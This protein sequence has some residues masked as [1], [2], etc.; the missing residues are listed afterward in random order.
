MDW[1]MVEK[2]YRKDN[3]FGIDFS[4]LLSEIHHSIPYWSPYSIA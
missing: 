3:I 4:I 1:A 2:T